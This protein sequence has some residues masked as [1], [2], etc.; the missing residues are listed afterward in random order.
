MSKTIPDFIRTLGFDMPDY[1]PQDLR[2]LV[3]ND[4][5]PAWSCAA[6]ILTEGKTPSMELTV[7]EAFLVVAFRHGNN[8]WGLVSPPLTK[9]NPL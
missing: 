7:R 8:S 1:E 9:E 2:Q 4:K 3:E 6:N 5:H